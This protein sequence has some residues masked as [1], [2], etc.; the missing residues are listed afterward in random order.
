MNSATVKPAA[1]GDEKRWRLVEAVMRRYGFSGDALIETLH[2]VQETYGC[3]EEDSMRR[4]A[5]ALNLQFDRTFVSERKH[6]IASNRPFF[7]ATAG[8]MMHTAK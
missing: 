1:P 4:V 2:A 6:C 7:F 5:A 3:I 8:E